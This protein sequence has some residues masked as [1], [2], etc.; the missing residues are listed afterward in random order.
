MYITF[1]TDE[2][3]PH[4][5]TFFDVQQRY[6]T[7]TTATRLQHDLAI[8]MQLPF[9]CDSTSTLFL[10]NAIMRGFGYRRIMT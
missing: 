2:G 8:F 3:T 1:L 4:S 7:V 10:G 9:D 6:E 5:V